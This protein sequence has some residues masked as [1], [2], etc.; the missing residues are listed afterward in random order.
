VRSLA[1]L[2]N[3][4]TGYIARHNQ[5]PGPLIWTAGAED[6]INKVARAR[7]VLDKLPTE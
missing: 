7:P 2:T 3:A 1:D 5:D 4:I 6:I